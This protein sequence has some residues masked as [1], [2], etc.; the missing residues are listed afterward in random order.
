[1]Q[2]WKKGQVVVSFG[3]LELSFVELSCDVQMKEDVHGFDFWRS[4]H[5][6]LRVKI[7]TFVNI[8]H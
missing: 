5:Q 6:C 1:M 7:C 2:Q 8:S 3:Y 4:Y